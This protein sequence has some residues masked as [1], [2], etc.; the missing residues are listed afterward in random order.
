MR[1]YVVP[2]LLSLFDVS[3]RDVKIV[4][5]T[6]KQILGTLGSSDGKLRRVKYTIGAWLNR[7]KVEE[8][9]RN[10][11]DRANKCYSQFMVRE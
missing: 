8:Y 4:H 9:I 11:R 6:C 7:K 1:V 5:D 3:S 10:L 2:H